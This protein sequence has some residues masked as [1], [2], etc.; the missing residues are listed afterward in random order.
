MLLDDMFF[1]SIDNYL[2]ND[3]IS[4]IYKVSFQLR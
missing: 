1:T 2:V 4:N 3:I